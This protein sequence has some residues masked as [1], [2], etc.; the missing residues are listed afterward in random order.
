MDNV[1]QSLVW[2]GVGVNAIS[3]MDSVKE[4]V[5]NTTPG[6]PKECTKETDAREERAP[7]DVKRVGRRP[8]QQCQML[9]RLGTLWRLRI[10]WQV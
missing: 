4:M 9:Q 2:G 10:K 6:T 8:G 5:E 3:D 7:S 1:S